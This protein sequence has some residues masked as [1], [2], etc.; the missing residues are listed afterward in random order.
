MKKFWF[1]VV[2]CLFWWFF[3]M[4]MIFGNFQ[5]QGDGWFAGELENIF[6]QS[7]GTGTGSPNSGQ[8]FAS[9]MLDLLIIIVAWPLI[10]LC[11]AFLCVFL[12]FDIPI[13]S[14]ISGFY[15]DN[16]LIWFA[17]IV[18]VLTVIGAFYFKLGSFQ[19]DSTVVTGYHY[20]AEYKGSD[21][22]VEIKKVEETKGGGEYILNFFL[23]LLRMIIIAAFGIIVAFVYK[24]K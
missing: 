22:K 8:I 5:F 11:F 18:L 6:S 2:P 3:V 23:L 20:E 17:V 9:I 4:Y 12:F 7:I 16:R 21:N 13:E 14:F 24:E 15:F 10:F 19:E 1:F